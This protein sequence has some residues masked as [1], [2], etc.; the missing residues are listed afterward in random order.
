MPVTAVDL[1]HTTS[2]TRVLDKTQVWLPELGSVAAETV[3]RQIECEGSSRRLH[4]QAMPTPYVS[5]Q[6]MD[7]EFSAGESA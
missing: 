4:I 3:M 6:N 1:D 7:R 2:A 5:M